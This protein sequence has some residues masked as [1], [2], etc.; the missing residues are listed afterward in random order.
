MKDFR[1]VRTRQRRNPAAPIPNTRRVERTLRLVAFLSSDWRNIKAMVEHLEVHPKSIN[2]Y[3][4]MLTDLGFEV[5][6][7]WKG[8]YYYY[9]IVNTKKYFHL[10]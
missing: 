4:N 10:E 8:R 2:R 6:W 5:Q 3:L 1:F 9:R 7:S